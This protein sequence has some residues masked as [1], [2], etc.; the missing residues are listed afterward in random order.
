MRT[1]CDSISARRSLGKRRYLTK[2]R[3]TKNQMQNTFRSWHIFLIMGLMTLF[4]IAAMVYSFQIGKHM[5]TKYAS[6]IDATMMIRY[7]CRNGP[8]VV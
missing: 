7:C 1:H 3:Q 8:L 6:Q 2:V 5:T 4:I